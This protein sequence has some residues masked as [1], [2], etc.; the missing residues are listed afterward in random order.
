MVRIGGCSESLQVTAC[1][2]C[3]RRL[4]APSRVALRTRN[5]AV[6]SGQFESHNVVIERRRLPSGRGMTC[7][8]VTR[9]TGRYMI[10][11]LRGSVLLLV[12]RHT[13]GRRPPEPVPDMT[14]RARL[15]KMSTGQRECR[16]RMAEAPPPPRCTDQ[17][18]CCA[19]GTEA[20]RAMRRHER[21]VVL[22]T[23][24]AEAV[25]RHIDVFVLLLVEMACLAGCS[26]VPPHKCEPGLRVPLGHIRHQPRPGSVAAIAQHPELTPMDVIM[27]LCTAVLCL[28]ELQLPVALPARDDEMLRNEWKAGTGVIELHRHGHLFPG[29]RTM[30]IFAGNRHRAMRRRLGARHGMPEEQS[31]RTQNKQRACPLTATIFSHV[32]PPTILLES[33]GSLFF[34]SV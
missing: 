20:R 22:D 29:G 21:C 27:T 9:E 17:M 14:L 1:T 13:L 12:T 33:H 18:T 2:L 6:G 10:R 24:A 19:I 15:G 8:T 16:L 34:L 5:R 31:D 26:L 25:D 3:R 32:K 30:A 28:C 7:C 11:V 4:V 23:V